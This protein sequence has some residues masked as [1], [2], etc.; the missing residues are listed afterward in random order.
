MDTDQTAPYAE[1]G[2]TRPSTSSAPP[3]LK[4]QPSAKLKRLIAELGLRYRPSAQ[5]DME[6]HAG[7]LALLIADLM[8]VPESYLEEA[9]RQWVLESPFMPKA[10]D[11]IASAKRIMERPRG[12]AKSVDMAARANARLRGEGRFD[13]EWFY[14][15]HGQIALRSTRPVE[16]LLG[17][18]IP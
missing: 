2:P 3:P 16:S 12:D 6:A 17:R 8:D 7:T 10:S 13:I 15:E 4:R 9:I 11:L 14:D 1:L 5:A 18:R